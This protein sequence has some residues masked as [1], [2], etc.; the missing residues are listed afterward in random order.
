MS[1]RKSLTCFFVSDLHGRLDRYE[2]LFKRMVAERPDALFI[3]GD[4][5]PNP[6]ITQ[7]GWKPA[8]ENFIGDYLFKELRQIKEQLGEAYPRIFVILGNDDA[9]TEEEAVR[10]GETQGLWDYCHKRRLQ[11]EGFTVYGYACI[12]PSPFLLKDWEHY[13]AGQFV[14]PG[15]IAPEDGAFTVPAR[16]EGKETTT[17]AGDLDRLTAGSSLEKTIFLFHSPPHRC[18]LDRAGLEGRRV[19]GVQIDVHVGSVAIRQ[20]IERRRPL[21]TLHGHIHESTR[22]TGSWRDKFANTESF[23]AS[24]DGSELSL[25]R[26]DPNDLKNATRELL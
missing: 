4:L 23:N 13:D 6:I 11:W 18:N 5:L 10:E 19:D 8:H 25:I 17:I 20:F 16:K 9:A 2:Q 7:G 21:V 24:T 12:P 14:R 22:L 26:F 3:G 1:S 15:C